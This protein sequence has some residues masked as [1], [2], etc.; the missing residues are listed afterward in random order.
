MIHLAGLREGQDIEIQFTGLRPGE[1]L[2]EELN[3]KDERILPTFHP[4]IK[5]FQDPP[6]SWE[7]A[8]R[9]VRDLRGL[10]NQRDR[11]QLLSKI[12]ELVAEYTPESHRD[13]TTTSAAV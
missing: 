13:L 11:E 4:K 8:D 9:A 3:L 7:F 10:V 6:V 12:S 1:K 5:V 2:F